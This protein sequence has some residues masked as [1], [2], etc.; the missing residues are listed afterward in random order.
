M[1]DIMKQIITFMLA[2][3]ACVPQVSAQW[4]VGL[5]AGATRNSLHVDKS[6]AYDR[7]YKPRWGFTMGIPV[8]Y[9]FNGWFGL[10]SGLSL[11]CKNYDI[12]RGWQYA[13]N[14]YRFS[15]T[16]L[17]IPV[18]ARFRFGG[19]R[20]HGYL[21]AGGYLGAWLRSNVAGRQMAYFD[22]ELEY[23]TYEFDDKVEFDSRRDNRFD[24]GLAVGLGLQYEL[25]HH[26]GIFAE[27]RYYYGLTD[28]QKHYMRGQFSRYSNTMLFQAGAMYEFNK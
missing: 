12:E 17:D 1:N 22:H 4:S 27:A 2:A 23:G 8:R 6:Y 25:S 13:D 11:A 28:M 14:R 5:E 20:L 18:F 24:A 21:L 9:D 10:Q 3:T 7:H 26:V 15:N 16:F 19:H